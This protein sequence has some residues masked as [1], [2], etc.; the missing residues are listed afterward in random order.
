MPSRF[1][2]THALIAVLALPA[3]LVAQDRL[4]SGRATRSGS[5]VPAVHASASAPAPVAPRPAVIPANATV[6]GPGSTDAVDPEEIPEEIVLER[7][8]FAYGGDGRRDPYTS[9]MGT[10]DLRPLPS[11]LRLAAVAFDPAGTGSVAI[12]RDLVTDQQYRVR[13]GQQLGRMRVTAIRQKSIQ[14]TIEEYGINR[15]AI[16]TQQP[17]SASQRSR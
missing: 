7:E 6:P 17:D 14:F 13:V 10:S 11:D 2:S 15:Q 1:R 9:L 3:L 5:T 4:R 16:L 8:V 12:L